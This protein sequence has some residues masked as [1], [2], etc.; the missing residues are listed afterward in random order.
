MDDYIMKKE[1]KGK[2]RAHRRKQSCV[3]QN[4]PNLSRTESDP[5]RNVAVKKD[6]DAAQ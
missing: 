2:R 4:E 5:Y 1:K 6:I 3:D